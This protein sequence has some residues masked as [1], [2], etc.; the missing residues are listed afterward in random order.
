MRPTHFHFDIRASKESVHPVPAL[1][2][3]EAAVGAARMWVEFPIADVVFDPT[4]EIPVVRGTLRAVVPNR[5]FG[6]SIYRYNEEACREEA[7]QEVLSALWAF[8]AW[9]ISCEAA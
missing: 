7:R 8:R 9:D 5:G 4:P 3:W 6:E 1:D 2:A